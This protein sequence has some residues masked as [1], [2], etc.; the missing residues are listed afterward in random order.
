MS[1]NNQSGANTCGRSGNS[2]GE[3][4]SARNGYTDSRSDNQL[5]KDGGWNS[6]FHMMQSYGLSVYKDKDSKVADQIIEGFRKIDMHQAR[7]EASGHQRGAIGRRG[8]D[9]QDACV[10]S[11]ERDGVS[12][13]S[14]RPDCRSQ[15][16]G[17]IQYS[18]I[19]Q[20]QGRDGGS[21]GSRNPYGTSQYGGNNQYA[22]I[23]QGRVGGPQE[24]GDGHGDDNGDEGFATGYYE[25][26]VGHSGYFEGGGNDYDGHYAGGDDGGDDDDDYY[27]MV[28]RGLT[29][30]MA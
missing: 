20:I 18:M 21:Q 6:K 3:G 25:E 14:R 4:P 26:D 11:Q 1:K 10:G 24:V 22:M 9:G 8:H 7:E 29:M 28:K 17:N 16:G 5:I 2:P 12:Q 19:T 27:S 30:L 13:D 15:Y 23:A